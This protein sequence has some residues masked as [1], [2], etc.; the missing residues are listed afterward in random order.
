MKNE[1]FAGMRPDFERD[2]IVLAD[3]STGLPVEVFGSDDETIRHFIEN[4]PE[5]L[6]GDFIDPK[7]ADKQGVYIK[8]NKSFGTTNWS[9]SKWEPKGPATRPWAKNDPSKANLN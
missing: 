6:G 3:G 5:M 8:S 1:R 7:E 4:A 2:P 9:G